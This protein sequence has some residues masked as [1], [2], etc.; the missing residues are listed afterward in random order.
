MVMENMF[1]A[2]TNLVT[3][4]VTPYNSDLSTGWTTKSVS[5]KLKDIFSNDT[6]LVGGNGTKYDENYID[7]TY[8][9]IDEEENPGY[10]TD[11]AVKTN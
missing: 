7:T 10:L 6:N 11:I 3:I 8:A 1:N 9:H 4:Y 5:N 2:C